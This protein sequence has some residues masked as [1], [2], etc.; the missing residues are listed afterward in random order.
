MIGNTNDGSTAAPRMRC[1]MNLM[2]LEDLPSFSTGPKQRGPDDPEFRLKYIHRAGYDGVQFIAPTTSQEIRLC[3]QFGFGRC[4]LGRVNLPEEA[5]DLAARFKDE[6]QECGTLHVGWGMEDD[7]TAAR[8]IEAVLEASAKH[9]VPLYVETH[10]ATLFQ[11]NWRTMQFV[12]RFP[13][14]RFNGDFSHWY[15]GLEMVY[16]GF[17]N[18]LAHMEPVIERTRFLH[19]RIGSPGCMQVHVDKEAREDQPFVQHF[20]AMWTAAFRAFLKGAEPGDYILFV[21]ELL[22]PR[23]FYERVFPSFGL[24]REESDRWAQSIVLRE[25]AEECFAAAK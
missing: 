18:K 19:G 13:D 25:I 2:A 5:G 14:L 10:R 3:E 16:G 1:Y 15:T 6:G 8:L 7:D 24:M 9:G 22:S 4:S 11:D 12:Q 20:R 21:P 17:E 23:I